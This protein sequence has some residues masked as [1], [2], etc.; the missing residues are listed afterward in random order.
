MLKKVILTFKTQKE[1]D[2]AIMA[3]SKGYKVEQW[4]M[5]TNTIITTKPYC[6]GVYVPSNDIVYEKNRVNR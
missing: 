3:L 1:A 5:D 6:V 2:D 4:Y